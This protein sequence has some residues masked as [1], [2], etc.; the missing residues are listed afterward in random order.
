ALVDVLEPAAPN[1]G[2]NASVNI[3]SS[4]DPIP[5]LDH[6]GC[7]PAGGGVWYD[8]DGA[9][10]EDLFDPASDEPGEYVYVLIGAEPCSNASAT[11]VIA[12]TLADDPGITTEVD[13]CISQ[14][15]VDLF[16][17][18]GPSADEG[19]NWADLNSSNALSGDQFDPSVA[20]TGAWVFE[21]SFP[22][23]GPCPV[24]S[25]TV[26]VNVTSGAN[27]G[28]DSSVTVCGADE[29]YELFFALGGSP[30]TGGTWDDITG[31]GSLS[32]NTFNA[33]LLEPGTTVQFAYQINDP[34]CG[35]VSSIVTA[36]ISDYLDPGV[37]DT[38]ALCITSGPV[39]L[40]NSLG[41]TPDSGGIWTSPSTAEHSGTFTPG[42][43]QPGAYFYN[44]PPTAECGALSAFVLVQL[45]ELANAGD[46]GTLIACDT[47]SALDLLTGLGPD[48]QSGG[49]WEDLSGVGAAL[50]NGALNTQDLEI[51][52]YQFSY[53]I[54]VGECG[55]DDALLT[56]QVIE[57][58]QVGE[59]NRTCNEQ[60]R[61]YV[62]TFPITSGDPSTYSVQG[63]SGTI[64][65]AAP[66][67]FTSVPIPA[68]LPFEAF[69]S[70]GSGCG[71]IQVSG[72]SPCSFDNELFIPGSFSPNGDGIN[73]A[74][75][76][77]GIQG[78]PENTVV[79][80]N[81]WGSKLFEAAG[82][83]NN[84]IVWDGSSTS[85]LIPGNVPAG[86]YF[87]VID[88]GTGREPFSGYIY[89]NR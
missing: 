85:S 17:A 88:I 74:F 54:D 71:S 26:T 19:G 13:A 18:L 4:V 23:N 33:H 36:T 9:V 15:S 42:T 29:E 68:N 14:T 12:I 22:S 5:L 61:T 64:S 2:C 38:L 7:S 25:S 24:M 41:G 50:T 30:D 80:F 48:A 40:I 3:C 55:T 69:V 52:T 46:D 73:E 56:V 70:D 21:Y 59:V 20:G 27:A 44:M 51:G 62:V 81:R 63:L 47:I 1:A 83:D 16:E 58:A 32:G 79:I 77:P 67:I 84:T 39:D 8:L 75:I 37:S 11:L 65:S 89:L 72:T 28:S 87:Y 43:D 60:A 82:Y 45:V 6:L 49:T 35:P 53:L 57:G 10:Q 86:T 34:G 31:S 76:I 78:Y 66:Y